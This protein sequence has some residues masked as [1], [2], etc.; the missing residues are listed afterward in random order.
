VQ[1]QSGAANTRFVSHLN[2]PKDYLF[3]SRYPSGLNF[4]SSGWE[5]AED[6]NSDKFFGIVLKDTQAY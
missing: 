4:K 6:L 3:V 1:K 2:L 5:I